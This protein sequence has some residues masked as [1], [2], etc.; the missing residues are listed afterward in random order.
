MRAAHDVPVYCRIIGTG[1][2]VIV[3]HGFGVDHRMMVDGLEPSFRDRDGWQR[4][5]FDLPGMG[6][7]P[8]AG[9]IASS[10]DMLTVVLSFL[11]A[12]IPDQR[13]VVVGQSYG[14][15]LARGVVAR[16]AD[17]IDGVALVCPMIVPE[18]SARDVPSKIVLREEPGLAA[19]LSPDDRTAFDGMFAVQSAAHWRRFR[20]HVLPAIRGADQRFLERVNQRYAFSFP[21]DAQPFARPALIVTGRQDTSVGYRDAWQII[22]SFPRATFAV[23]DSASHNVQIEQSAL[24]GALVRDWLDRIDHS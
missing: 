15:Y 8:G 23:L 12:V 5:Y 20:D 4:I 7:T 21:L 10:D 14:G 13:F 18:R 6:R 22:E 11:D 2:P 19:S 16:R 24:L 3:L 17:Q 1:R 9:A